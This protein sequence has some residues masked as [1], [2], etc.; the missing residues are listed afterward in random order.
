VIGSER[1][2]GFQLWV[3]LPPEL[4]NAPASSLYLSPSEVP[5]TG[6]VR[7]ILGSYDGLHSKIQFPSNLT[8][9]HVHLPKG[10][11][12]TYLPP[13]DHEVA[14]AAVHEGQIEVSGEILE[15][16]IAVFEEGPDALHFVAR[17][18][19]SFVI[20]SARKHPYP[21]VL[22]YYSVHTSPHALE[23]GEAGIKEVEQTVL[24]DRLRLIAKK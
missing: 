6:P 4:E 10:K 12:W 21:L 13:P 3:A 18:D 19:A 5:E 15:R 7:V 22:G 14:W 23:I 2:R 1:A 8:Y 17:S 11:Q 20:G 16:E 24:P 9:L